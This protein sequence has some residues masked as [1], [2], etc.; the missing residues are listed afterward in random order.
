MNKKNVVP[1]IEVRLRRRY[2]QLIKEQSHISQSLAA[3]LNALPGTRGSFASTQGAW[4]FYRNETV[5]LKALAQPLVEQGRRSLA[6]SGQEYGLVMHDWSHLNYQ[7]HGSKKD[8]VVKGPQR[9]RGYELQTSLL[10]CDR[11]GAA[12]APL[13][14]NIVSAEGIH[15]TRSEATLK[16]EPHL[17]ELTKRME[18]LEQLQLGR[19]VV[20]IIDREGDSVGHFRQWQERNFVV[21]VKGG[22][23][24]QWQGQSCLLNAVVKELQQQRAF[25]FSR[26]VEYRGR[27]ASQ[28]IA[29]TEVVLS[30]AARPRRKGTKR[31]PI[32]GKPVAL[33]LVIS[34]VRDAAGKVLAVWLLLSNLDPKVPA[35]QL[36]LWYYWRW[37]I[38][39]FF[40]L[41][42]SAGLQLEHWQQENALAIAKR[43]LVASMAC[44][45]IWQLA[46]NQTPEAA[47][48]RH[49]LIRLSGRQMKYGTD[50]TTPALLE[51]VWILL[52]MLDLLENHD[53]SQ[54]KQLA[55]SFFN[56]Q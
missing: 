14:Q 30:R 1:E 55:N 13:C 20:H 26:P 15:S 31:K 6:E 23:R 42:K 22:Q 28:Y 37:R 41:L 18:Y 35:S 53:L 17:D 16:R 24:V 51:G 21:R 43:L 56:L 50:F 32:A 25:T 49:V 52:S 8:C 10:V 29:E 47:Q 46:R 5:S 2:E 33:R 34:E 44:V 48:L 54:L 4:R 11:T 40:K 9:Q 45:L 39:S 19:P 36:A 27:A 38:E 7:R 3:G 12:L